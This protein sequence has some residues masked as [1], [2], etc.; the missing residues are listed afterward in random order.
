MATTCRRR[1]R[2]AVTAAAL[3]CVVGS[4][5][6]GGDG[7][8]SA[9]GEMQADSGTAGQT[10]SA[11]VVL[12]QTELDDPGME[13]GLV[14][15]GA[16]VGEDS[17]GLL[18]DELAE[19]VA[20]EP[21]LP[22]RIPAGTRINAAPDEDISTASHRVDDPVVVKVTHDVTGPGAEVL[23]PQGV[24]LLGRVRT[25]IGSGGPGEPVVL[26][27]DFETLSAD[28]Y[29]RPIEGT[30]VN[31]PV[32]PD[33]VAARRQRTASRRGLAM[34]VVPGLIMAGTIIVVELRAPVD[35]PPL[36]A[37]EGP[38]PWGDSLG[39]RRDSVVRPDTTPAREPG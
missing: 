31:R 23:I 4:G 7:E 35:V 27:I 19:D 14:P 37:R 17:A 20:P 30:V 36:L 10:G 21:L 24:R 3:A 5:A 38:V 12:P 18:D 8:S 11:E 15:A 6:C 16:G 39:L 9:E 34:A 22:V 25:A 2:L 32:I 1:W 26:E 29:E 33:P 13:E 28:R